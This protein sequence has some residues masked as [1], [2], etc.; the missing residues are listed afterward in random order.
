MS[1]K[2]V[3]VMGA[4]GNQGRAA[5]EALREKGHRVRALVRAEDAEGAKRLKEKGVET[6]TGDFDNPDSLTQAMTGVDAVFAMTTPI[7]GVDVEVRHGKA[8]AD[9][10]VA[11]K[12]G[13]L[14]Y[15][16][17]GDADR[18]TGIPHFDS[19]YEIE[20]YL[21][22]LGVPWTITAPAYFYD[23]ALFPWN[24]ADMN[25]GRFRQALNPTRKLQQISVR[26]IGRFNAMVIDRKEPFIGKR[27]NIAG[28]ELTGVEMAEALD[29]PLLPSP[30][31]F[32]RS[33]VLPSLKK[34]VTD[35]FFVL[36]Y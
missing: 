18:A 7:T 21:R 35:L 17:V 11:A 6:V 10:A 12:V 13:H 29:F 26:D 33:W 14:V 5:T 22:E 36:L 34:F 19:K 32:L 30:I 23:N 3:L 20:Q 28:D 27:I 2:T 4:T 8:I 15:S 1:E 24:L 31:P 16:S 9:A 25:E